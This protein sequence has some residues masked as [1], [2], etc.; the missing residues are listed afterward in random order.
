MGVTSKPV[1]PPALGGERHY[2]RHQDRLNAGGLIERVSLHQRAK[3]FHRLMEATAPGPGAR[4]L[5][6]GV[7]CYERSDTNFF[8]KM[9]PYLGQVVA[10]GLEDA[11]FLERQYPG[12][13]YLKA[14]GFRLPFADRSFDLVVSFAV[15]EHLGPRERQRQFVSELCRVGRVCCLTTPNRW[16]PLEFHTVLP[17]LHWLPPRAFRGLLT[18]MGREFYASEQNLNLLSER[19][20]LSFVPAGM[21]SLTERFRLFGAVSNLMLLIWNESVP[22]PCMAAGGSLPAA[23]QSSPRKVPGAI[24]P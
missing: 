19:D 2:Y 22:H 4:V 21:A 6:V 17:L 8:E 5:D 20:F 7:T 14:S 1:D 15:I 9:Y 11:G 3:M 23:P 13:N 24:N 12:L 10:V 18:R 16:Y